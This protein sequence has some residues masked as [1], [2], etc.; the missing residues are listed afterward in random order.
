M[1]IPESYTGQPFRLDIWMHGTN[2][3]LNE[4]LFIKQ[5][6]GTAPVPADQKHIQVDVYGR[7]NV[8]YRWAGETD[9]F[10]ALQS[11]QERYKIDPQRI[12]LRGFSMGGAGAWHLGVHH[13]DR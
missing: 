1:I 13:P 4:V 5:H 11:V 10:E 2:R 12:A 6:E 7:S 8:A 3:N 9:V